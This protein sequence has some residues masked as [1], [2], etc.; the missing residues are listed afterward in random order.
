MKTIYNEKKQAE[1]DIKRAEN[2][3]K[4]GRTTWHC[5]HCKFNGNVHCSEGFPVDLTLR[6][7]EY[8]ELA[9]VCKQ[10]MEYDA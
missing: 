3:L 10:C 6:E 9:P 1:L 2:K 7:V 8:G 5:Y 4:W